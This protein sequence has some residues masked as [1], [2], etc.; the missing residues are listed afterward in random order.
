MG[1]SKGCQPNFPLH[2][3]PSRATRS[4]RH[5]RVFPHRGGCKNQATRI[6]DSFCAPP[7][8]APC[9]TMSAVYVPALS[10]GGVP[11]CSLLRL[12]Q[13]LLRTVFSFL[14]D[15]LVAKT[16]EEVPPPDYVCKTF[17]LIFSDLR[18]SNFGHVKGTVKVAALSP[19]VLLLAPRLGHQVRELIVTFKCETAPSDWQ[20]FQRNLLS[21]GDLQTALP[22][23]ARLHL[24]SDYGD[25][26]VTAVIGDKGSDD[27]D[28][29]DDEEEVKD[30]EKE[31]AVLK[32]ML[33]QQPILLDQL[34]A[35]PP[36]LILVLEQLCVPEALP[37]QL[38]ALEL[39]QTGDPL[40][41]NFSRLQS[42]S[43]QSLRM[44]GVEVTELLFK[45]SHRAWKSC[46]LRA[47][48]LGLLPPS[49]HKLELESCSDF[50]VDAKTPWP[51]ESIQELSLCNVAW[52][53]LGF[54]AGCSLSHC[55]A[56]TKLKIKSVGGEKFDVSGLPASL[57]HFE[58]LAANVQLLG[59]LP[60]RLTHLALNATARSSP[61]SGP[62]TPEELEDIEAAAAKLKAILPK[63][64]M[65]A[66]SRSSPIILAHMWG[67]NERANLPY[68]FT[69]FSLDLNTLPGSLVTLVLEIGL[70]SQDEATIHEQLSIQGDPLRL[71]V[72]ESVK[73]VNTNKYSFREPYE[74]QQ[75]L[76]FVVGRF[77]KRAKVTLTRPE[78]HV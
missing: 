4:V 6:R 77:S 60:P 25:L 35:T 18:W 19:K 71:T 9:L 40:L 73:V 61:Q 41:L 1:S 58:F 11:G 67:L 15:S 2:L 62:G 20:S 65:A 68:I 22:R 56:L 75:L 28:D 7:L 63:K 78:A 32:R 50:V 48:H 33:Q 36:G 23:L 21:G 54:E 47:E 55:S 13:D 27:D 3:Q 64:L 38:A 5:T 39:R 49:L 26:K 24:R 53:M 31:E 59:S 74:Q 16:E 44:A 76:D 66:F 43:I 30:E 57:Q 37:P 69:P 17:Q 46:G 45:R 34:G 70:S 52:E 72:L 42:S 10:A 51:H 8:T 14:V 29:D 12:P